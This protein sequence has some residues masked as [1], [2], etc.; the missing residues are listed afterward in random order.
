MMMR[1]E[2]DCYS[3]V[4]GSSRVPLEGFGA[5]QGKVVLVFNPKSYI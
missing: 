3:F 5:L 4:T 2:Q 1:R